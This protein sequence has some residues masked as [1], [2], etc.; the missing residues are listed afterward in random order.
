[1]VHALWS[2]F[3]PS[4]TSSA[5]L[6]YMD[7]WN[8]ADRDITVSSFMAIKDAAVA[9]SGLVTAR[10]LLT[11]TSAVGTGGTAATSEGTDIAAATITRVQQYALPTGITARLTPSG[12]ATA[13]AIICE[14]HI[15]PEETQG[16][17]GPEEFV[18]A[19]LTVPEGT[20]LRIVQGTVASVG[21]VGFQCLFY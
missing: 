18:H 12:G 1:M 4:Q 6:V 15:Y 17:Q 5:N 3:V 16:T 8:G 19:L 11:R 21:K 9:V 20:G 14:R 10:L 2:L 7:L 13:G